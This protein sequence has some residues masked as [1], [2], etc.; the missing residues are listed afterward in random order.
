MKC[1]LLTDKNYSEQLSRNLNAGDC[2]GEDCAWWD[3]LPQRCSVLTMAI[4]SRII[5]G[6]LHKLNEVVHC[7]VQ[8]RR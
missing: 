2:I 4:G 5:A 8:E 1:P 7:D 3:K 6:E